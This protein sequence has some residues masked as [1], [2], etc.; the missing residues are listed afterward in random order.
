MI[1]CKIKK[2]LPNN[3]Y[4]IEAFNRQIKLVLEFYG[5][6]APK[7]EDSLVLH[8]NLFDIKSPKFTQPYCFEISDKIIDNESQLDEETAVLKSGKK[9]YIL[10]RVYG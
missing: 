8:E 7:V 6:N 1:S 5:V 4:Q 3:V 9:V 10:K 2:C